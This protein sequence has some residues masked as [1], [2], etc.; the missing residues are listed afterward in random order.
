MRQLFIV[1]LLTAAFLAVIFAHEGMHGL[2]YAAGALTV[3]CFWM[4]LR[5][6]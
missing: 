5:T 2:S 4:F 1:E 6:E 3:F